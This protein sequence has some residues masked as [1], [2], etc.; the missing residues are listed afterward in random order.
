MFVGAGNNGPM[1]LDVVNISDEQL[2]RSSASEAEEALG[3]F[4]RR[5]ER[6]VLAFFVRRLR[7]SELAADLAAV[8]FLEVVKSR[9]KFKG[10][11]PGDATAWLFGIANHTLHRHWRR[12]GAESRRRERMLNELPTLT[13]EQSTE[14]ELLAE[15]GPFS[16]ALAWLPVCQRDAIRAYVLDDSTYAEIAQESQIDQAAARQRVSRGLRALRAAYKETR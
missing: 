12:E 13:R 15:E 10:A 16:A 2:L 7:D 1:P 11:V 4:Y 5:H 8:V 9:R 3:E 14:I 6:I